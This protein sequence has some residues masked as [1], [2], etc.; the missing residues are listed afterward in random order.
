MVGFGGYPFYFPVGSCFSFI[1]P[2]TGIFTASLD[3]YQS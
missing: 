3:L 2:G 1:A